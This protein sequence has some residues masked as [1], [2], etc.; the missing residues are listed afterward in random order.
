L[1]VK[2]GAEKEASGSN[3]RAAEAETPLDEKIMRFI[4]DIKT[5]E[6]SLGHPSISM[7]K[8]GP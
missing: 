2:E 3:V 5:G 6:F 7:K 8:R 4:P 1:P